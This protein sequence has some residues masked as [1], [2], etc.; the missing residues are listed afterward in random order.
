MGARTTTAS[1]PQDPSLLPTFPRPVCTKNAGTIGA[2]R[3]RA[4][5]PASRRGPTSPLLQ[6][7]KV[8]VAEPDRIIVVAQRVTDPDGGSGLLLVSGPRTTGRERCRNRSSGQ[9]RP[10]SS[11]CCHSVSGR[12]RTFPRRPVNR[13]QKDESPAV[14]RFPKRSRSRSQTLN[15]SSVSFGSSRT[16][17]SCAGQAV[18]VTGRAFDPP[19]RRRGRPSGWSTPA[20]SLGSGTTA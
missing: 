11:R 8:V 9:S 14:A 18:R 20:L 2:T 10:G 13:P 6:H 17:A 19:L 7:A 1:A 15:R 5:R 16:T 4:A 12:R 3:R